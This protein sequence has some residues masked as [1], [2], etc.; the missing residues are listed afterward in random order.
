MADDSGS[1]SSGSESEDLPS[2]GDASG[3]G[4]G[5]AALQDAEA[6]APSGRIVAAA[7]K[8]LKLT[9]AHSWAILEALSDL[10]RSNSRM[11]PANPALLSAQ[12]E[13]LKAD[14][15]NGCAI[16]ID[17]LGGVI[18]NK[19]I[20]DKFAEFAEAASASAPM[21]NKYIAKLDPTQI[22]SVAQ[23]FGDDSTAAASNPLLNW[24]FW[25]NG[26][27]LPQIVSQ[28]RLCCVRYQIGQ[29]RFQ[30]TGCLIRYQMVWVPSKMLL[31]LTGLGL[32]FRVY[33]CV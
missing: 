15:A 24:L 33:G 18:G 25:G 10:S 14:F 7:Q 11:A 31:R 22:A 21:V 5:A 23:V 32:G 20:V 6:S 13:S 19:D 3:G 26:L 12:L 1:G 27:P 28:H 2:G 9:S 17:G 4:G 8:D 16:I 30:Q 29:V